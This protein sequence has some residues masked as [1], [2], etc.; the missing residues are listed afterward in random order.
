NQLDINRLAV[1]SVQLIAFKADRDFELRAP[2]ASETR[3]DLTRLAKLHCFTS[4]A[5]S[6]VPVLTVPIVTN[7]VTA[8]P[9]RLEQLLD[10]VNSSDEGNKDFK[11]NNKVNKDFKGGKAQKLSE[12]TVVDLHIHELLDS[13]AGLQPADMLACQL[14]EFDNRMAEAARRPGSKII[15]IHGKGEG[16]LRAAIL[17]RL[18]RRWP[19]CDVQDASFRE[20]GFGATQVTI[21]K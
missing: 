13:T 5:Y 21:R 16:V 18:R 1:I 17:D 14:R 19:K 6:T 7:G 20:Y 12:P 10:H 2:I 15:F 3:M 4:T 8:R 9:L 11:V